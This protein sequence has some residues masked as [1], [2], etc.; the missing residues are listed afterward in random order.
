MTVIE[1][2]EELRSR[3]I[4]MLIAFGVA[5]VVA[6]IL[7]NP[8][9]GFLTSPLRHLPQAAQIIRGRGNLIVTSPTEPLFIRLK[10][11][12]F[13]ALALALPVVAWQTW[14][15]IAPG[16]YA[17]E[18]RYAIPF[19]GTALVLFGAGV[20]LAFATLPAALHLLTAFSGSSIQLLP[21]ASE[22]LSFVL[23]LILAFGVAL[24]FPLALV[25][26]S[27][28]GAISSRQLRRWR[29][30]AWVIILVVAGFLTPA[31]DP[32]SQVLLAVP[33]A[34]L[35]EATIIVTRVLRH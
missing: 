25:A 8:I 31:Q 12:S 30:P 13:S 19:V 10:V 15:F 28:V 35:Y 11:V 27:L 24:E 22:Y 5:G 23:L 9:L 21:R 20:A 1:H 3:I 2:L 14:R 34:V 29:R 4:K 33:M 18:K 6:W 32:I 16:L 7:Y 17:K 26:L